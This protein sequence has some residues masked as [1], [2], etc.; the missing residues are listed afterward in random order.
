MAAAPHAS[1]PRLGAD[2]G[3]L[4]PAFCFRD[5]ARLRTRIALAVGMMPRGE[6]CAG[7]IVNAIALDT[8]GL[9][10]PAITIAVL[11]LAV[12]MICFRAG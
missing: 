6:V 10:G 1:G 3:K 2:L 8:E 4:F 11:C 12:N 7:I 5:E 9:L